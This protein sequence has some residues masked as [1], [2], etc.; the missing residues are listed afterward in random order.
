[1]AIQNRSAYM[2][3]KGSA[4]FEVLAYANLDPLPASELA[5][6]AGIDRRHVDVC[7]QRLRDAGL[8]TAA[9]GRAVRATKWGRSF[10]RGVLKARA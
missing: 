1:M 3:T 5:T 8:V 4:A 9:R 6:Q 2:P 7:V 10:Y